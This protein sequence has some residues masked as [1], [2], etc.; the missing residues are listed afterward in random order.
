MRIDT[1]VM[2]KKVTTGRAVNVYLPYRIIDTLD[3]VKAE[4]GICRSV[5]IAKSVEVFMRKKKHL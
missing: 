5:L 4:T 2:K 3:R 1:H